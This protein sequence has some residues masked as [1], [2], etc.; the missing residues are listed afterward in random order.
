MM[1]D[2]DHKGDLR[3]GEPLLW[4][5]AE[6][7]CVIQPGLEKA[8][9]KYYSNL[10]VSQEE[11]TRKLKRDSSGHGVIEQ[12]AIVSSDPSERGLA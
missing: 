3:A 8:S 2:E 1:P 7:V 5:R 9:G 10:P 11:L 6:K 12:G 4:R